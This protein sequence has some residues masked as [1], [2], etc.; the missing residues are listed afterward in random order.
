MRQAAPNL[1]NG[2]RRH[3]ARL[4]DLIIFRPNKAIAAIFAAAG[5]Y[6]PPFVVERE[7]IFTV[8]R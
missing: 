8:K 7:E 3:A 6:P 5:G 4:A 2:K 1:H